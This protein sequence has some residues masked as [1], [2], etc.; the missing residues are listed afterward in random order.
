MSEY[1]QQSRRGSS[2]NSSVCSEDLAVMHMDMI[3]CTPP[4]K[5]TPKL[6]T[7]ISPASS[8]NT[9][10]HTPP[11]SHNLPVVEKITETVV[12][13]SNTAPQPKL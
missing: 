1:T 8:H 11:F 6:S 9:I 10:L 13:L 12:L 7:S 4:S 3:P 5:P 2:S